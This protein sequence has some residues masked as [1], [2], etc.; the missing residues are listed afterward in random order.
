MIGFISSVLF[1]VPGFPMVT[2][3]LDIS[4]WTFWRVFRV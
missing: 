4:V 2:G 1:L 3:M